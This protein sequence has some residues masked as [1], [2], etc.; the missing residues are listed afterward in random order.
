MDAL[1]QKQQKMLDREVRKVGADPSALIEVLHAAQGIYGYLEN[2]R[3]RYIADTLNLPVSKVYGVAT[4]YHFFQLKPKGKHTCV[5][6]TGTA[7]FI[8]GAGELIREIEA[9]YG[10]KMGETTADGEIT[11]LASRCFGA[12]AMAP[13]AISDGKTQGFLKPEDIET[14]VAHLKGNGS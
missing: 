10:I 9:T 11:F 2:E 13:A 5:I 6:C 12:C 1:A 14:I 7:C 4:F 8:K 3:L